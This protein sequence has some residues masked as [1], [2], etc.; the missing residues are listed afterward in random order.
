MGLMSVRRRS[1]PCKRLLL[2]VIGASLIFGV[3][4]LHDF[5]AVN[6][7]VGEG[8]LVV[9]AWIPIQSLAEA[10]EVF[11][12]GHYCYLVVVGGPIQEEGSPSNQPATYDELAGGRLAKLG[13]DTKKLVKV[14]VPQQTEGRRTLSSALAVG[15]WLGDLK[16]SVCCVDVF[17]ASVHARKSWVLYQYALSGRYRVGI[18]A[19]SEVFGNRNR[20]WFLSKRG[21]WIF[22]R[23]L[24]AYAYAEVLVRF[25]K[26]VMPQIPSNASAEYHDA[27]AL[28]LCHP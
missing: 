25:S 18:R 22:I 9:E 13:F 1:L 27:L 17:T 6:D 20:Y 2:G 16:T 4:S 12:R 8:V 14:R 23:N 26:N 10:K 11:N 21:I 3:K 28:G 5:L 15:R 19:G 7:P 24:A